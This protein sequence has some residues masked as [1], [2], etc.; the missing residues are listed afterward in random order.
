[1]Y[2]SCRYV[3]RIQQKQARRIVKRRKYYE[4]GRSQDA[5]DSHGKHTVRKG[6]AQSTAFRERC[7]VSAALHILPRGSN[8]S[9]E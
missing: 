5:R 2:P 7:S 6:K 8:S 1:M 3:K 4:P 9:S